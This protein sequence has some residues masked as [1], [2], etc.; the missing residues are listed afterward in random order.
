MLAT[1]A[2]LAPVEQTTAKLND[3]FLNAA[4]SATP[5]T[6]RVN[7]EIAT[8]NVTLGDSLEL[9]LNGAS[10]TTAKQVT[11]NVAH[12]QDGYVDFVVSTA[13]LGVDGSKTLTA[14]LVDGA[15]PSM[16][17]TSSPR[18]FTKDVTLPF[19]T[20]RPAEQS[21]SKLADGKL[22]A[23]EALSSTAIR[24]N[25]GASGAQAGDR[26]DL[27]LGGKAFVD[28]LFTVL[29]STDVNTNKYFDF[30]VTTDNLE[31]DGDKS[32]TARVTD[33]AGNVGASS[34]GLVFLKDVGVPNAP[35]V[36]EEN[37]S[38]TADGWINSAEV[39]TPLSFRVAL[40]GNTSANDTAE[41]LL[42][43]VPFASPKSVNLSPIDIADG[44][45]DFSVSSTE[46]G[47]DGPKSLSARV[48]DQAG[49]FG[50]SSATP[51]FTKDVGAPL[52]TAAPAE[53]FS[54]KLSD[55]IL[56]VTEAGTSTVIRVSLSTSG[57]VVGDTLEL[58]LGGASFAPAKTR[59][60]DALNI[61]DTFVDFVVTTADLGVDGAK[62]ITARVTDAAGNAGTASSPL[63][64]VKD[65]TAPAAPGAP[66]E[67]TTTK[68][69]DS[70]LNFVEA[71]TATMFR[72][73]LGTSG[74]IVGDSVELLLGGT[75]FGTPKTVV[76][77]ETDITNG[78]VEFTVSGT[79]LGVDGDKSLTARLTDRNSTGPASTAL[80]F[81]KDTVAPNAPSTPAEQGSTKLADNFLNAAEATTATTIRVSLSTPGAVS[82]DTI[83][84]LLGGA[85]FATPKTVTLTT[86][87]VTTGFIDF[88]FLGTDLG[89]DGAKSLTAR[90]TDQ[91]GNVGA[92]STALAF[93]KDIAVPNAPSTPAEQGSTK[94]ADNFL[95]ALEAGT[96]TTFRVSLGSS[97]AIEG[98]TVELLL[99]GASFA[100]P[101]TVTLTPTNVTNGF[102]DFTVLGTD[103]GAD[104][105]KSL[106]ARVTDQAGNVGAAST[107]ITFT[108]DVAAPNAPAAPTSSAL[109]D[110]WLNAT[111]AATATT[112][113][114]SLG[115]SGAASGGTV[116]LLLGG[117]S[118]ATPKTV[119][120]TPTNVTN[121][122]VDFTVLGTDLGADGA[123]SLTAR[124]TNQAGNVGAASSA[125]AFTKDVAAP[126]APPTLALGPGIS[127]PVSR[128]EALQAS[129]V[130]TVSGEA[131]SVITVTFAR[132]GSSVTKTV[133][134]TGSPQAVV[135]TNEA[136]GD[137]ARLGDGLVTVTASQ[138]DAAGNPQ[139]VAPATTSFTLDTA[140]A[141]ISTVRTP[142][143]EGT[144]VTFQQQL[145]LCIVYNE[146]V[147]I[148]T[149]GGSPTLTLNTAFG[150]QA[151]YVRQLDARTFIFRYTPQLGDA[152][153]ALDV[154]SPSALVLNGAVIRDT[155]GNTA[156]GT[157]PIGS[158]AAKRIAVDAALQATAQAVGFTPENAPSR[159][160]SRRTLTIT[161]NA[162]VSGVS[163]SSFK[164]FYA[165]PPRRPTDLPSFRLVSL[166]GA[167]V[168]GSG[169]TYT[170]TMPANL[171][172]LRGIYRVDVGGS[173]SG[174]VS[175]GIPMTRP[176]S[177]FWKRV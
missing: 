16:V 100:T 29:D 141:V 20:D 94:L 131:G 80:A 159:T 67:Q 33:A 77:T 155:A 123:K 108:K 73:S 151:I 132:N 110:G 36:P 21:T 90:V 150:G 88:T 176:T 138:T 109:A 19:A 164:L 89:A 137:L 117:A 6:I 98:D 1:G 60:L 55:N 35:A 71:G 149:T 76:L 122:F 38:A 97:G 15:N 43:G 2:T 127:N 58:L 120:L 171:T 47:P 34:L 142:A 146:D 11:L 119:T 147:N 92:A 160:A 139:T 59:L 174:V 91:A 106:T 26:L 70:R 7:L 68:L 49:N 12:I 111:E 40:G 125:L 129:G 8:S 140:S 144:V 23:V 163:L 152:V 102:V 53:Q 166:K 105:A 172:S 135:L 3:D 32:I 126:N 158:L 115:T 118:F 175:D 5:T 170:L 104:G 134:G 72:V 48:V 42:N 9:R 133:V 153:S 156:T 173:A 79:D 82:G 61:S 45:V 66:A 96:A 165:S 130:V 83:E 121:G 57:A 107:A 113:R 37:G 84:L 161:F 74:A 17:F 64:F 18:T 28:P 44:Y 95:N 81:T 145:K 41:L 25:L 75:A 50:L 154:A 31:I 56:K 24:V 87:N 168:T 157:L 14:R 93:T 22:N 54:T 62:S 101:K 63:A 143:A 39:A 103:L 162:P 69:N 10:F 114:V 169:T 85:S 116:E 27:L 136:N 128:A 112:V 148:D 30:V 4:E 52:A 99:G 51:I 167:T 78:Y 86:T 124:V 177:F 65:T 13:D 46:L